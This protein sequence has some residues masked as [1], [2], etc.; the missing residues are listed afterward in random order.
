MRQ[1][2]A[3]IFRETDGP[4]DKLEAMWINYI[5]LTVARVSETPTK[6]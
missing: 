5:G 2:N 6:K 4:V 3:L 1:S